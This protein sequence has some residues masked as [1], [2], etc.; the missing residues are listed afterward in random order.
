MNP[1]QRKL[2]SYLA[3]VALY[4]LVFGWWM[5]FFLRQSD[6][7]LLR[8]ARQGV[9]LAPE[10]AEALRQASDTSMRMFLVEGAFLGLMLAASVGLVVRSLHREVSVHR[11]QRNFLSAVTHELKSPLASARLYI[12]SLLMGRAEGEKRERYLRHALEDLDRLHA[13]VGDLLMSA[14]YASTG[15]TVHPE[16]VDLARFADQQMERLVREE[17]RERAQLE[18]HT[19]GPVPVEVDSGALETV[20]RN[21]ISNAVKYGGETPRIEVTVERADGRAVLRLR[22]HGRGL[23]GADAERIFDPFVRGGDENVRTQPGAGL[24]LYIVRELTRAHR[25]EV[26]ARDAEAGGLVVEIRL[27]LASDRGSKA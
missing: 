5:F 9:E 2:Y 25:G 10:Q 1:G 22:D 27:P 3:V 7:L 12:E 17:S 14:Q 13:M 15:P 4:V 6:Y 21:L 11:Q 8:M 16:R 26:L 19:S 18:L 20:L 23:A 24:G